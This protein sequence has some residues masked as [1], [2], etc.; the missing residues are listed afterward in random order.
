MPFTTPLALMVAT[1]GEAEFQ[2][3][4]PIA[5]VDNAVVNVTHNVFVPVIAG[6]AGVA[7]CGFTVKGVA[8]ETQVM[9]PVLRTTT[10]KLP[11][12]KPANIVPA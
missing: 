6:A 7:G 9:S 11:N 10:F 4:V 3:I 8:P 5:V 12:A 2:V 1:A